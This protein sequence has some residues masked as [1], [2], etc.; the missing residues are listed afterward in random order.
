MTWGAGGAGSQ[1]LVGMRILVV[2]D[3]TVIALDLEQIVRDAGAEVAGPAFDVSEALELARAG[4][5]SA[6][7]LD[8]RL[9]G[10]LVTPVAA[11]LAERGVPFVFYSGQIGA[12]AILQDW[13]G[14]AFVSKPAP[15]RLIVTMLRQV[16][17]SQ[18]HGAR[19]PHAPKA[20]G[21]VRLQQA[22]T[23]PSATSKRVNRSASAGAAQPIS[24]S[25]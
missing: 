9:C 21:P 19:P 24:L 6:A 18:R 23:A 4:P 3:E 25:K 20:P 15:A 8:V 10:Q 12:E 17:E 16:V 22:R 2:D 14:S 7:L 5:L 1:D 11:V 13:P